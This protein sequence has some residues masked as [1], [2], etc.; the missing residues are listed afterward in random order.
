M[1]RLNN[2][3]NIIEY[4]TEAEFR[5]AIEAISPNLPQPLTVE[6]RNQT[7]G[8]ETI[9]VSN[10]PIPDNCFGSTEIKVKIIDVVSGDFGIGH[11]IVRWRRFGGTAPTIIS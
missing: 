8:G 2:N 3:G 11:F 6:I 4:A 9:D 7:T 10:F 5:A 1:P